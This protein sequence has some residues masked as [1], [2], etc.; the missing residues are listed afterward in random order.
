MWVGGGRRRP[1]AAPRPPASAPRRPPGGGGAE[2]HGAAKPSLGRGRAMGSG[3]GLGPRTSPAA[4]QPRTA[5][6]SPR[7]G[8]AEPREAPEALPT[9][10]RGA[11]SD[12]LLQL[13]KPGRLGSRARPPPERPR[14]RGKV[15]E[16]PAREGGQRVRTRR[17]CAERARPAAAR[18]PCRRGKAPPG[19]SGADGCRFASPGRAAW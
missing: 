13:Q 1:G 15:R 19:R 16:G 7:P 17:A 8:S 14:P 10:K 9:P 18:P 6:R 11:H 12:F 3:D 4:A 2:A 5:T